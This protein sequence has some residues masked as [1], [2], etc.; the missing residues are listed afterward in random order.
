[1]KKQLQDKFN[2]LKSLGKKHQQRG[3]EFEK[4]IFDLLEYEN[5]SPSPS[6]R[7]RGE[8]IDGFFEFENRF[9]LL[10]AKWWREPV[11][12]SDIYVF[13]AKIEGRL[14]GTLGVFISMAGY[15]VE[16]P[17]V[18]RYGKE[19]NVILFNKKDMEFA[20]AD[21]C[22]FGTVLKTKL[23]RAAQH[24]DVYYPFGTHLILTQAR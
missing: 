15:T 1:M 11:S 19:I 22:S 9:F 12:V 21:N 14:S 10:E 23:R 20:L 3:Y 24:G 16:V 8:Q 4:F 2:Q 7:Y 6:Y 17:T 18:L 13:R 5:L